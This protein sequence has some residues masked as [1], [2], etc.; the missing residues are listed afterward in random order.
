MKSLLISRTYF[1]PQTGGISHFMAA[2]ALALGPDRVCCL[3]SRQAR[4]VAVNSNSGTKVY[5]WKW[6]GKEKYLRALGLGVSI[7]QIILREQPQAVQLATV[8][9]GFL[10]LWL[11]QWLKLPFVVF[12]HGNEI[13]SA[14]RGGICE[15]YITTLQ[16]ADRVLAVS[17]FTANLIQNAG[18]TQ[19]RIEIVHPGCDTDRF[20]PRHPRRELWQRLLGNRYGDRVIVTVSNLA[21]RKGHDMVIRAIA[22]LRQSIPEVTYLIVG[23]GPYRG[24]LETLAAA[25]GVQDRV[26][27]AG[28]V[29]DED[30]PDVY[31]LSEVFVMPSRERL[32]ENDVEG[33]GLVFL[34]ANACAKPV[35]GGWSGGVPEAIVDGVTGLLVDPH[36][37]EEIANAL[38][39]L[40]SDSDLAIRLGRQG[41]ARVVSNFNWARVGDR[42][43]NILETVSWEKSM[44][45]KN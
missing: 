4:K 23:D 7:A 39:R 18:V 40:L 5:Y 43:H 17:Q 15:K 12:A 14:I 11:Q 44:R 20:R 25:V 30:L 27:F 24:Q 42:V 9:E 10:G 36:G 28:R 37:P 19:A 29:A 41:R 8:G 32:E 13:L 16:R 2:L 22:R 26:I 45:R 21:E 1:P 38:A 6:E 31:A 33:F 35:V 34:E 3:T